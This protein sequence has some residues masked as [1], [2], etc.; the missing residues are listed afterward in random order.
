MC[1]EEPETN[2]PGM[3]SVVHDPIGTLGLCPPPAPPCVA[4]SHRS[5]STPARTGG[6]SAVKFVDESALGGLIEVGGTDLKTLSFLN[7]CAPLFAAFHTDEALHQKLCAADQ[8][9]SPAR[10]WAT[11]LH[12]SYDPCRWFEIRSDGSP[13]LPCRRSHAG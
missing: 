2:A 4:A 10:L 7:T 3:V 9:G 11:P 8:V 6:T 1:V 5:N 12:V 13:L